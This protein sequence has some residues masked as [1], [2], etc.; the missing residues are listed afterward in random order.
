[1]TYENIETVGMTDRNFPEYNDRTVERKVDV[2]D[3]DWFA[4]SDIIRVK[5]TPSDGI[6]EGVTVESEA[7]T[8]TGDS[9]PRVAGVTIS[10]TGKVEE[11][12]SSGNYYVPAGTELRAYYVYTD[13]DT[14]TVTINGITHTSLVEWFLKDSQEVYSTSPTIPANTTQAGQA[15][16]F[17][18]TPRDGTMPNA[19]VGIAVTSETVVIR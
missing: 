12:A 13:D 5:V 2:G 11:P 14:G 15:F 4:P 7:T 10:A 9:I 3:N 1:M 6:S 19:H 16:N 17:R 8:I 18:V